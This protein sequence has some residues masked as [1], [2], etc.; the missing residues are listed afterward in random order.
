[1][2]RWVVF[3]EKYIKPPRKQDFYTLR[4]W[5][6]HEQLVPKW[7]RV[8]VVQGANRQQAE[9]EAERLHGKVLVRSEASVAAD[10]MSIHH[11][12]ARV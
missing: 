5:G 6:P 7:V 2:F 8:G 4:C 9:A 12:T 1:M 10:V 11:E 3:R